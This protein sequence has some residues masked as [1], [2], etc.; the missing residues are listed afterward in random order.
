MSRTYRRKTRKPEEWVTHDYDRF[1][2]VWQRV[3]YTGKKLKEEINKFHSDRGVGDS[4]PVPA[5]FRRELNRK[6]RAKSKAESRRI[7]LQSDYDMYEFAPFKKDAAWLW[8]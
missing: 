1:D 4:W 8:W 2:G 5:W 7:L 6:F 3:P